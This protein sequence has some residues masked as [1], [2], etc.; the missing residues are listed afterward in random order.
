MAIVAHPDDVE[1][2][3]AGTLLLLKDRGYE[4]HYMNV[5]SGSCGSLT[6]PSASVRQVRRSESRDAA[7]FM[8]A[9]WHSSL[10]DDMEIVYELSLLRRLAVVIRTVN[11]SI[12]L[13]HSPQDYMEDHM[14]T[15]RLAVSAAFAK[16]MPNFGTD[17]PSG[18][19]P[20]DVA[21]YHGMPH[22][23]CDQLRQRIVPE[24]FV[25]TTAVH[26]KKREALAMHASQKQW[27]DASQGMDS[28][29]VAMDEMS[30]ELGTMSG[31][32]EHAEGW[33]RHLH[34]GFSASDEDPLA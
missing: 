4:I 29:L 19:A 22:G 1:F 7:K 32:F 28:Y 21:I 20:G 34:L 5:A 31:T 10:C 14:A 9:E 13:T 24:A 2:M 11:P 8:G 25:D 12:I 26:G 15:S 18:P 30:A 33:R 23:L 27:L 16:N 3:A 6:M 17:P